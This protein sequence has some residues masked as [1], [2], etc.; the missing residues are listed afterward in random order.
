MGLTQ[1]G[2]A[3]GSPSYMSPEQ[4]SGTP[5]DQRTDIYSLGCVMYETLTGRPAFNGQNAMDVMSQHI[6]EKPIP[7][8][9]PNS[10]MSAV[11]ERI[12]TQA[13]AKNPDDRYQT[14]NAL[15]SD[16]QFCLDALKAVAAKSKCAA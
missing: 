3:V 4:C 13:M 8:G 15:R 12:V 14:A 6:T 5:L 10:C 9:L 1:E 7:M 11:M 2:E 16:M